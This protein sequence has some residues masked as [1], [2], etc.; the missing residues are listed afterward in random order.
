[1]KIA[2]LFLYKCLRDHKLNASVLQILR[3]DAFKILTFEFNVRSFAN[4]LNDTRFQIVKEINLT[5][6]YGK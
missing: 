2:L 5:W 6:Y 4:A 3:E 1:M